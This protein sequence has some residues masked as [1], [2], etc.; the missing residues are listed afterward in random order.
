MNTTKSMIAELPVTA[1]ALQYLANV[2]SLVDNLNVPYSRANLLANYTPDEAE[3]AAE[4]VIDALRFNSRED[5]ILARYEDVDANYPS[6][7]EMLD[8]GVDIIVIA[9]LLQF[10]VIDGAYLGRMVRAGVDLAAF[11]DAVKT[12]AVTALN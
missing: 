8:N 10:G 5:A 6:A 12:G 3:M 9:E 1:G 7:Q 4:A 11:T 2:G